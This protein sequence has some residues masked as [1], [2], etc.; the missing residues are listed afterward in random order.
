M[1]SKGMNPAVEMTTREQFFFE[2]RVFRY[3]KRIGAKEILPVRGLFFAEQ[4]IASQ[5]INPEQ[6]S[7][8]LI[9]ELEKIYQRDGWR[10]IKQ[11]VIYESEIKKRLS[12]LL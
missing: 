12:E 4:I 6:E 8:K 5:K 3:R 11:L 10:D 2:R 1:T 7:E 9:S